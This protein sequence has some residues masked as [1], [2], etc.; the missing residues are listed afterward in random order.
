[1][2]EWMPFE[3]ALSS[4]ACNQMRLEAVRVPD[5]ADARLTEANRRRHCART[6]VRGVRRLFLCRLP[7]NLLCHGRGDGGRTPGS[8]RILL[9]AWRPPARNRA[10]Q[11]AAF[12]GV[13]FSSPAISLFCLP[14]AASRTMRERSTMRAGS[15]RARARCSNISRCS[16]FSCTG[17]AMRIG[18]LIVETTRKSIMVFLTHY[19]R[20]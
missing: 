20:F 11:R 3:P 12:W 15:D 18:P 2:E 8:R 6:P 9:R 13:I 17:R 4:G 16:E 19:T 1:M 14:A 10:R 5:S 7:H